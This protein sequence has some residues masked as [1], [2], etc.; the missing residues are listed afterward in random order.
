MF[1]TGKMIYVRVLNSNL[2]PN[3]EMQLTLTKVLDTFNFS[4]RG[5]GF[6]FLERKRIM[7]V[8]CTLRTRRQPAS[9]EKINDSGDS[10]LLQVLLFK[11][12]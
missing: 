7:R 9:Y 6:L 2:Y 4:S 12:L 10:K 8:G 1:V 3:Y 5:D 11:H